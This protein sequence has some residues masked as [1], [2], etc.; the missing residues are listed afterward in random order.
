MARE[1]S[2]WTQS[3]LEILAGVPPGLQQEL[4]RLLVNEFTST[5]DGGPET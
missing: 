5:L 1:W 2:Y 3:K 4:V